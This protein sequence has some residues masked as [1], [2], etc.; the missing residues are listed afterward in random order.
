MNPQQHPPLNCIILTGITHIVQ[1]MIKQMRTCDSG[2]A[3]AA[4]KVTAIGNKKH[5]LFVKYNR[6]SLYN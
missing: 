2:A 1:T 4:Y 5:V 3:H 6:A